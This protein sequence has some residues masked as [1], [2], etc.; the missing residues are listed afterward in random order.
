[1]QRLF[2]TKRNIEDSSPQSFE[3]RLR[4]KIR[5]N[6]EQAQTL[7]FKIAGNRDEFEAA[8][9]LVHDQYVRKGYMEKQK[10][11]MRLSLFHAMPE[12]TTFVGKKDDLTVYTLTLFQDSALGL[13]MDAIYKKELDQLRSQGRKIAEVGALA[14]HSHIQNE[15][16]TVLMYGN[17]AAIRY[18][19]D[20]LNVDDLVIAINPKHE[21]F[22]EK[23]M[24]LEKIGDVKCYDYVQEAPAVAYR[25]NLRSAE[26]N[27][28]FIYDSGPS[29]RNIYHFLFNQK[30]QN[31]D[32]PKNNQ[33][34]CFWDREKMTYFFED[35]TTLFW[36]ANKKTREYLQSQYSF[37]IGL[38]SKLLD[39]T[40]QLSRGLMRRDSD[41]LFPALQ[42]NPCFSAAV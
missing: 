5:I 15:D 13:P 21:W 4:G 16:Q 27:Y 32:L 42:Q 3:S 37:K 29:E 9:R 11:G 7:K 24:L 26:A 18:S 40:I 10:S 6:H 14:S 41:D 30:S 38:N 1:M 36:K 31:I 35:K 23:I 2:K 33:P 20:H 34:I 22:Y 39:T 19:K 28:K 25:L 8:C 17:K 12:T